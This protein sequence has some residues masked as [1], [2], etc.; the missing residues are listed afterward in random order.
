MWTKKS[1]CI[2]GVNYGDLEVLDF[3]EL[4]ADGQDLELLVR[5]LL[6]RQGFSVYWS[7]KGADGGRDLICIE[8]RGSF[9]QQD[10][11]S[12]LIQCKHNANSGKAVGV[13]DLDDIS[14]SCAHHNC[15][16]YLLVCSTCPSS[17]VVNRLE[18]ISRNPQKSLTATYW[19]SVKI[20]QLLSTPQNWSLAQRFFPVS[21]NAED[22]QIYA[23]DAPNQW[24]VIYK[25]YYFHLNNRI[26]S[27]HSYHLKSIKQRIVDIEGITLPE[28]HFLRPRSVY[29]DDKNGGYEWYVDYMYPNTQRAIFGSAEIADALGD[30]YALEDGQFYT[31]HV[32]LRSYLE[33]SDHYDPDHYDYY[34]SGSIPRNGGPRRHESY[35]DYAEA[36]DSRRRSIENSER[37]KNRGF[38]KLCKELEKIPFIKV[39][40]KCNSNIE[41][42]DKF[43]I[44]KNWSEIIEELGLEDD[45]FFSAWFFIK[46][47]DDEAFHEMITNFPQSIDKHFRLTRAHIYLPADKPKRSIRTDTNILSYELTLSIHPSII[48]NKV[49]GRSLLNEYFEELASAVAAFRVES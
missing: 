40:R 18:G 28:K 12:W 34:D 43:Y 45:K 20:E 13:S 27:R 10:E 22:W 15:Q 46:V 9:F 11:R 42:L 16:G 8:R 48:G 26:G 7:G 37:E 29:Y 4:S 31:F 5:E 33:H 36:D 38:D 41:Y 19:D 47:T 1:A 23:T 35:D 6:F 49:M 30:G 32:K 2:N 17:A 44:Q 3:T 14:D 39:V 21:A 25:G 24:V